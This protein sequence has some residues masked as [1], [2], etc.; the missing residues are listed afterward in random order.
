M[1]NKDDI[2]K[3]FKVLDVVM[4]SDC[5]STGIWLRH[6]KSGLEVFHLLNEDHENSFAFAFRTPSKDSTGVAHVLEH[7]VLC[8]SKKYPVK[9]P[10]LQ[11][12]NQ[13]VNTYLNAYTASDHTVFPASSLVKADF[14]NLFSVYADAVFFP[15]LQKEIF[16]QECHRIE[17]GEDGNP[18]IQGVVFNEMKGNYSSFERVALDT[19]D[20]VILSGTNY[21]FDSGGDPLVIPSLSLRDVRSFH[22]KYYCTSNCL[23]F[24]YG[25]IP[26]E[27]QLD[28]LDEN[29]IQK[30][31]SYGKKAK[32]PTPDKSI[33]IK[34]RVR[35]FGPADDEN[36]ESVNIV[37]LSWK[38]S[39][40]I[41]KEDRACFNMLL[42][43][44]DYL[45]WGDDSAAVSKVLLNS[46]LGQDISPLTGI[47]LSS[48]YPYACISMHGVK[49]SDETRFKGII[50]KTLK[51]ICKNGFPKEDLERLE[52]AFDISNREIKRP[53]GSP[54]SMVLLRKVLC[55]WLYGFKPWECLFPRESFKAL[56]EN[57]L[58]DPDYL[59]KAIFKYF[60][61]NKNMSLVSVEPSSAWSN[62]RSRIELKIAKS[63][64]K[65][66]GRK[67]VLS[68]L[69]A[70][71]RYQNKIEDE[72][73]VPRLKISD[74]TSEIEKIHISK[75]KVSDVPLYVSKEQ[76][77]GILYFTIAFPVDV[78]SVSDYPYL[79]FL[80]GCIA[81]IGW[82]DMPWDKA[83]KS[84]GR[85]AGGMRALLR[86][87]GV[88]DCVKDE[89]KDNDCV[90][91][92]WLSFRFECLEEKI[93]ESF[94]LL[95]DC[96]KGTDFS[97]TK[98][99]K[100]L[101]SSYLNEIKYSS[102]AQAHIYA[103]SRVQRN[104]NRNKA[105]QELWDGIASIFFAFE[106]GKQDVS[107]ISK[108]LS[109]LLKKIC[110]SGAVMHVTG[111]SEGISVAKKHIQSF[112]S[113]INLTYP[114]PRKKQSDSAFY[115][116]CN[117]L[118]YDNKENSSVVRT[119]LCQKEYFVIPGTVGYAVKYFPSSPYGSKEAVADS[120]YSH[121][122]STTELWKKIRTEGGAYGA[123]L[124]SNS[125]SN[126]TRFLTYRD[127]KPF[128][129]L[130]VINQILEQSA[131][132]NFSI[133]EVEKSI[134]G[135]YSDE[136]NPITP[137]N[138][139]ITGFFRELSGI[140]NS[141]QLKRVKHLLS[142]SPKDLHKSA[143]RFAEKLKNADNEVVM[144]AKSLVPKEMTGK[145]LK[146][147]I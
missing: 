40:G 26:T 139:G 107:S 25:S 16:M 98:R 92:D 70:L 144:C 121:C 75:T 108:K 83:I 27:E 74:L 99:L 82:N 61:N 67:K 147:P 129:A 131:K 140:K 143:E 73:I 127:P 21:I 20:N 22:K 141:F 68:N 106:L 35:A 134:T 85:V 13:S 59:K 124:S 29:V 119:K 43:F 60:I 122:L 54:F 100:D 96:I 146:L 76:T 77:N 78:L 42:T 94:S 84:I 24:L 63:K 53:D 47:S 52:N 19:V 56:Q 50:L 118:V 113:R 48:R 64:L 137:E 86:S 66:L 57:I 120:V 115:S 123:Y 109:A 17:L 145:I 33:S 31:S 2:Y 15:L 6:E 18:V 10:F 114:K 69:K 41:E 51:D 126:I 142:I 132:K 30:V 133:E 5:N 34:P 28:F 135:S 79:P 37:S 89:V 58:Q 72:S 65:E 117:S 44:L 23:V 7:S 36:K 88:P 81:D 130:Q 111:T 138:R 1:M 93:S 128:E 95:G 49:K 90:G 4:V 71:N 8:G 110:S 14:F 32:F 101:L 38:L 103:A 125:L 3:G 45:L 80:A 55:C 97:D 102:V 62:N 91:R 39:D 9:D 87:T 46:D 12:T 104:V 11:L 136:I 112:V 105:I 116:L